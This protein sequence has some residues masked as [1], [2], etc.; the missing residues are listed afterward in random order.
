MKCHII[1][2]CCLSWLKA[3]SGTKL[4]FFLANFSWLETAFCELG[5]CLFYDLSSRSPVSVGSC[6][7]CEAQGQP[8]MI[9]SNNSILQLP[10]LEM[11]QSQGTCCLT[12]PL[13][14]VSSNSIGTSGVLLWNLFPFVFHLALH[15]TLLV[16]LLGGKTYESK[17]FAHILDN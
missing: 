9:N 7:I 16:A 12:L 8:L 13:Q 14:A 6:D 1:T 4:R 5:L 11:A 10:A 2:Y 15:R 17:H 3:V